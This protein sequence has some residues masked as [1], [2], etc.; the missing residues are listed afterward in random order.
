MKV[1][2]SA[3]GGSE[4]GMCLAVWGIVCRM[5]WEGHD[6]GCI[7]DAR[8]GCPGIVFNLVNG[9]FIREISIY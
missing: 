2:L 8:F 7:A 1:L 5:S 6:V 9:L 4:F 3:D